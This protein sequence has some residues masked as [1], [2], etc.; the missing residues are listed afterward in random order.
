MAIAA[1]VCF[2]LRRRHHR[3]L[4][5]V[6]W[7]LGTFIFVCGLT[8]LMDVAVWWWPAY[9]L[10]CL[11]KLVGSAV[12]LGTA[13]LL[14]PMVPAIMRVPS[15][16]ILHGRLEQTRG[17]LMDLQHRLQHMDEETRDLAAVK[18]RSIV[19]QLKEIK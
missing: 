5:W 10:S 18:L 7:G 3:S 6:F 13:V 12:S 4:V 1:V 15:V 16:A 11:V 19:Q 9:H 8:H 17:E 14:V 2:W